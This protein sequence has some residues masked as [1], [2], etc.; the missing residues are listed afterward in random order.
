MGGWPSSSLFVVAGIFGVVLP[1]AHARGVYLRLRNGGLSRCRQPELGTAHSVENRFRNFAIVLPYAHTQEIVY[2]PCPPE[3]AGKFC[4]RSAV[5]PRGSNSVDAARAVCLRTT[6]SSLRGRRRVSLRIL[7]YSS[8]L[9]S[10]PSLR[11]GLWL[12]RVPFVS[13][14]VG[15]GY[16]C[17]VYSGDA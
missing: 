17:R 15:S 5:C 6:P 14:A 1:Y 8:S 12:A 4:E 2:S 9:S 10:S 7:S 16:P 11:F 3:G 13:E